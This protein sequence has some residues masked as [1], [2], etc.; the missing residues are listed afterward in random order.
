VSDNVPRPFRA[1][2][3]SRRPSGRSPFASVL[4]L[5]FLV[6]VG[7][8]LSGLGSRDVALAQTGEADLSLTKADSPDPAYVGE[9]LTYTLTVANA[10]PDPAEEVT[11]SDALPAGAAFVSASAT[12]GSCEQTGGTVD[13]SLGTLASAASATVTIVVRPTTPGTLSNT[14]SVTST[15][16]DPAPANNSDT[17][18]T[19]VAVPAAD[20]SLNKADSPDPAYVGEDLTYTL[21]V[22][23][24]GPNAGQQ[25][26]VSDPLPTGVTYVSA[27]ASQGSCS[28]AA[29][30][31]DCSLGTL[32]NAASATVT[33]VVRPTTP[34][35]LSNTASVTST[36]ADP[37]P[38]NNSD[39]ETTEIQGARPNIVV[40][41]TDDQAALDGRLL[42]FQ[43]KVKST[44][45]EQGVTFSDF[46]SETP[47][48][49]PARAGFLS[50][51]HTHNH[52][53]NT[54]NAKLFKPAMSA[55]T[56]L[57]GSGYHTMLVG[58]YMNQYGACSGANC[59]PNVPPGWT[60]WVA[61]GDPKYYNYNLFIDG[62]PTAEFHGS[63]A[64][65]Y[66]T[67]VLAQK[68]VDLIDSAPIGKP[69][70]AWIAPFAPHAP[71]TPAPR[72]KTAPCT[73]PAWAPPNWNEADVSDKPAYV[74][75]APLLS[76][77]F[78]FKPGCRTLL[79]VD[80]LVGSVRDAL[81][82]TGRLGNTLFVYMGD[83]GMNAGEHRLLNK[84]APYQTQI[85]FLVSWPDQL[86]TTPRT[87]SERVQ[88]IDLAPTLCVFAGC[89]LGPYPNGQ[90]NPDGISFADLLLGQAS[91][92]PRDAVLD[93]FP[94][95]GF[96]APIWYAVTTTA[97]SPLA[98]QGCA[99]AASGLC[100]WHYIE[101]PATGEKELYDLSNGPCWTW[102]VGAPGD[103]CE[104]DNAIAN[105]AYAD[106]VTALAARLAQLRVEKGQP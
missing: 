81:S 96:G 23:N 87:I 46:H 53:V 30:T 27:S 28:Q 26:A 13:C 68:S 106:I 45:V 9:D 102:T 35:T 70:F 41:M 1:G 57:Q 31:V 6:A 82:R 51:Q 56:A 20:L 62:N 49:C 92:L 100:K 74:R 3:G 37:A 15:T 103:P 94:K 25:V 105:P 69:V 54:N 59:A 4:A 65:H 77:P 88:N 83:N 36:T 33:I 42:Q 67:D 44:F 2:E 17:E 75:N 19:E 80:D 18:T 72:H 71:P 7:G 91:S 73:V 85:P 89:T 5:V 8:L 16:A 50:G 61:F 84:A 78:E 76:S 64:A 40:V 32:A 52:K 48:C 39:T 22:A 38:A 58:K 55:A 24:A 95:K 11:V 34:G 14:A 21:T 101:Y 93:E 79:A 29:G 63:G 90:A 97:Q 10:G 104:L 98:F 60:R 86:G 99:S 43:P 12:Q 66:S 47:L